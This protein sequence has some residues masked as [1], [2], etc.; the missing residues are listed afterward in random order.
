LPILQK[1]NVKKLVVTGINFGS[2]HDLAT[3][4]NFAHKNEK[5]NNFG[6]ICTGLGLRVPH[7]GSES[8]EKLD[9]KNHITVG[10]TS[11]SANTSFL[12]TSTA[13]LFTSFASKP[14]D[15]FETPGPLMSA[16]V[17]CLNPI[18]LEKLN[19]LMVE[20]PDL[21]NTCKVEMD[22]RVVHS[23]QGILYNYATETLVDHGFDVMEIQSHLPVYFWYAEDDE[24]CPPSHGMWIANKNTDSNC[25]FTNVSSRSFNKYGHTGTAFVNP[26]AFLKAFY[27]HVNE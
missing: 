1:E 5:D 15:A 12:G 6:V 14:G 21:M 13:R 18:A 9:L 2:C 20:Y 16:F 17:N 3:V 4:W 23:D 25:H 8:C 27:D 7:L 22:R 11:T 26:D 24:D 10:F 19:N